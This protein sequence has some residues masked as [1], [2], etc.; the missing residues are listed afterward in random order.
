MYLF[1]YSFTLYIFACQY[2]APDG[3]RIC[4]TPMDTRMV[5]WLIIE[6]ELKLW[7]CTVCNCFKIICVHMLKK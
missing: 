5:Y 1:I 2:I 3:I 7:F 4:C 6:S